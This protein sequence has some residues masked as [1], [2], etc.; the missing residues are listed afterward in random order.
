MKKVFYLIAMLFIFAGCFSRKGYVESSNIYR[1]VL[2][3]KPKAIVNKP[4]KK[5]E[6]KPVNDYKP[7]RNEGDIILRRENVRMEEGEQNLGYSV[8]VGSFLMKSNAV[9]LRNSL[10]EM[11]YDKSSIMKN[12]EGMFRV[13]ISSFSNERDARNEVMR[14][15]E[16]FS[17]FKDAWLLLSR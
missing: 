13:S 15:K 8:I 6:A 10:I 11:G 9:K 1:P 17:Q 12:S 7:I 16:N 5:Q 14:V 3:N 2:E 4:A